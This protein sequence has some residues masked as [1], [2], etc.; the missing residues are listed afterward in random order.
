MKEG[1]LK[2]PTIG[3]DIDGVTF[4]LILLLLFPLKG[5]WGRWLITFLLAAC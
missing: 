3:F 4:K 2:L 1:V 5:L